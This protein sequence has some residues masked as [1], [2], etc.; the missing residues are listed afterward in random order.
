M[1]ENWRS[2]RTTRVKREA[3]GFPASERAAKSAM[4]RRGLLASMPIAVRN[5][6]CAA[7]D[8]PQKARITKT[9]K[10]LKPLR[11]TCTL[12]SQKMA[13]PHEPELTSL[14]YGRGIEIQSGDHI[15]ARIVAR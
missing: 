14:T 15:S 8:P 6:S 7:A 10:E 13:K 12:T 2:S 11:F 9:K 1:P 4:A 5:Q 3:C